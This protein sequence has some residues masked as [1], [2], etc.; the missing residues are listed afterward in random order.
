M[1]FVVCPLLL[2]FCTQLLVVFLLLLFTSYISCT[3]RSLLI[4]VC[5]LHYIYTYVNNVDLVGLALWNFSEINGQIFHIHQ[6]LHNYVSLSLD[7]TFPLKQKNNKQNG[8]QSYVKCYWDRFFVVFFF[9]S[10]AMW[11]KTIL[12]VY[13]NKYK[14]VHIWSCMMVIIKSYSDKWTFTSNK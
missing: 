2:I 12:H 5:F 7:W 6:F 1:F 4:F 10:F 14:T 13:T 3:L 9:L 11:E 8:N